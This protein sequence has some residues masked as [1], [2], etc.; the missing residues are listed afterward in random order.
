MQVTSQWSL[1]QDKLEMLLDKVEIL[2][3]IFTKCRPFLV[4]RNEVTYAFKLLVRQF[5]LK[6]TSLLRQEVKY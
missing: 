4:A 6:Q 2:R 3:K 5:L 1:N